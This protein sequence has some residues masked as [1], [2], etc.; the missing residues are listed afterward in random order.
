M[1]RVDLDSYDAMES[2][3]LFNNISSFGQPCARGQPFSP[4]KVAR[5][6]RKSPI[7]TR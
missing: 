5:F 1:M 4:P 6:G 3:N 7:G 2:I